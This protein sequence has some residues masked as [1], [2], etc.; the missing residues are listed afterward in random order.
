MNIIFMGEIRVKWVKMGEQLRW[1]HGKSSG[2]MSLHSFPMFPLAHGTAECIGVANPPGKS[3]ETGSWNL[4]HIGSSENHL[5]SDVRSWEEE[6]FR[7]HP[8]SSG[9]IRPPLWRW[10][11]CCPH[12]NLRESGGVPKATFSPL[13]SLDITGITRLATT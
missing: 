6:D 2:R 7:C 10:V 4:H 3:R 11:G 12:H 5:D 8:V 9:L 1:I 13:A